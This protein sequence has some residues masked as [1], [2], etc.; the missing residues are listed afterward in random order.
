M[1]ALQASGRAGNLRVDARPVLPK[2]EQVRSEVY[3]YDLEV[4]EHFRRQGIATALIRE[5]HREA[6]SKGAY[7]VFVQ[8]D[9]DGDPAVALYTKL[10]ARKEVRHFD[11]MD[12][13]STA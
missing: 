9:Y 4:D 6:K 10:G 1:R 8:A 2:F 12:P 3:I 11:I 5:L 7:V 13:D